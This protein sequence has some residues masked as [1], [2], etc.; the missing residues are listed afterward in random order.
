[1]ELVW[2]TRRIQRV[3]SPK[4]KDLLGY[5]PT[6]DN[7]SYIDPII[8][9]TS[10]SSP[11]PLSSVKLASAIVIGP[12]NYVVNIQSEQ[13]S[14][15]LLSTFGL[16]RSLWTTAV[17]IYVF[18]FGI[19]KLNPFG[20]VLKCPCFRRNARKKLE[21]AFPIIPFVTNSNTELSI[22]Q[23]QGRLNALEM[24]LKE[25]IFDVEYLQEDVAK[26]E[27]NQMNSN[28]NYYT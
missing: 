1:M 22:S 14:K 2:F 6:L 25:R 23:L 15:T 5:A 17:G 18:L 12:Q 3:I 27:N 7:T 24:F 13:R 26:Q 19:D 4:F 8:Q 21:S 9:S 16:L 20:C 10:F 11:I 28:I